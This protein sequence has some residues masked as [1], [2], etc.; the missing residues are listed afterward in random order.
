MERVLKGER[1]EMARVK[2]IFLF[3]KWTISEN[4]SKILSGGT[5]ILKIMTVT[6]ITT[7]TT[8]FRKRGWDHR[9]GQKRD[10]GKEDS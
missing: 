2:E 8:T 4:N 6:T 5:R 10:K 3:R 1:D 9:T 7:T